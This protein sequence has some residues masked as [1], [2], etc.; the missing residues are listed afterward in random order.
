MSTPLEDLGHLHLGVLR[1]AT[2]LCAAGK[3]SDVELQ[4][5]T[6]LTRAELEDLVREGKR[7]SD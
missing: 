2:K 4:L 1:E 6:H 7:G 3:M 5:L